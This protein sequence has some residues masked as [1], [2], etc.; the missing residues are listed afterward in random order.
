MSTSPGCALGGLCRKPESVL[1]ILPV[2]CQ[3][4]LT[5]SATQQLLAEAKD[6]YP[7]FL[8]LLAGEWK[9]GRMP[10]SQTNTTC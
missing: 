3:L 9:I 8:S 10:P 4:D 2:P 1:K 7:S 5:S 6:L